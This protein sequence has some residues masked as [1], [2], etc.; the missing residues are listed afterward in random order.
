MTQRYSKY[1]DSGI[2]WI[3]EI[4]EHW[5]VRKVK[6]LAKQINEKAST[7]DSEFK[8]L[9]MENIESWT[10]KLIDINLEVEGIAN[11][12]NAGNVLFGKLRPYL[13][14]VYLADIHGL[15]SSEFIVYDTSIKMLN[16]YFYKVLVSSNFIELVNASTYGAKMPRANSEFIGNQLIPLP[17]L[18]EQEAIAQFLDEKCAR[19]DEAVRIKEKQIDLLKEYR[20]ITIHQA[21][22]KGLND[23]VEMKDSGIDWIGEIPEHW[24]VKRLKN[25]LASKLK[26]GANESGCEY[27]ESLPRYIRISDFGMDG[28]LNEE[29]KLSLPN[30]IAKDYLLKDRDILFA[31]SGATVGKAYQFKLSLSN[32]REYCFAGYLIKAEPD[33][34]KVL[35]DFLYLYTQSGSFLSWKESIFNKA[36]IE[37]IGA[38]KYSELFVPL[39]PLSEQTQIVTHLET[40]STKTDQAIRLKEQQIEQLKQYKTSLINDVVTGKVRVA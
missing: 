26:Y 30:E 13:A 36:T 19:I 2:E 38:D 34:K 33:Y 4:P 10:G 40:L 14:K 23:Q 20:Q 31:R 6:F 18:T 7:K 28:R 12:F 15:C 39:P 5:E 16:R 35:S 24:E 17:P 22:T 27:H 37:N 29:K 1:K 25:I 21:V 8:Y 3:G 11:T 32:E 9:G